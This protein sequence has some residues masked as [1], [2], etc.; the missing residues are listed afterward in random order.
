MRPCSPWL[1]GVVNSE[2]SDGVALM[3]P[4]QPAALELSQM[5]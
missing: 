2:S 1:P 5:V 4:P 3:Y